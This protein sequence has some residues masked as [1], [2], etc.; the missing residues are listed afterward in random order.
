MWRVCKS[1]FG[2]LSASTVAAC[3]ACI[4][5]WPLGSLISATFLGGLRRQSSHRIGVTEWFHGSDFADRG[6]VGLQV[7]W[8]SEVKEDGHNQRDRKRR[9]LTNDKAPLLPTGTRG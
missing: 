2:A 7:R 8:R 9:E 5:L 1:A 3:P 4:D 6:G